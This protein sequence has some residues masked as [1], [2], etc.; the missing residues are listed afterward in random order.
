L[1]IKGVLIFFFWSG[2]R[3][4]GGGGEKVRT[5]KIGKREKEILKKEGFI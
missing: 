1:D 3:E 2:G 5:R 4:K